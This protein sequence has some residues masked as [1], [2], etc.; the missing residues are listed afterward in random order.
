MTKERSGITRTWS[1]LED[2]KWFIDQLG[3]EVNKCNAEG[4]ASR[5]AGAFGNIEA[6]FYKKEI[7]EETMEKMKGEVI[8][9]ISYFSKKC[10]CQKR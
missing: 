9:S 2:A 4:M 1:P 6:A 8:Q 3:T 10:M 5:T 7:D